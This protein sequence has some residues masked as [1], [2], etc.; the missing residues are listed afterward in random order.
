[1][2]NRINKRILEALLM[3]LVEAYSVSSLD[4]LSLFMSFH[5]CTLEEIIKRS[6]ENLDE[7]HASDQVA[8]KP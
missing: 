8:L 1:M 7:H 5:P 2:G 3:P 6:E 4:F